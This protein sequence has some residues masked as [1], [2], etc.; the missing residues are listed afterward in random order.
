M[1]TR[2]EVAPLL[3]AMRDTLSA[4]SKTVLSYVAAMT[5]LFSLLDLAQVESGH[6]TLS[7]IGSTIAGYLL[8]RA[9][10]VET[11]LAREGETAGFG[12]YF[13]MG[14]LEGL[15]YV[16]GAVLLVVPA[17]IL[18]VRWTPSIPLL[19]CERRDVTESM[20]LSW[21]STKDS[22]WPL[23]GLT[24]L[25]AVPFVFAVLVSGVFFEDEGPLTAGGIAASLITNL[26][27]TAMSAYFALL[28]LATYRLLFRPHE[29]L[30][31]VFA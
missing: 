26:C 20:G 5:V 31:E 27:I 24:L 11:G 22:F 1:E 18:M 14:F 30:A 25:G 7:S 23:L 12:S 17:V 4:T 3:A 6:F 29:G 15:A 10:V 21:Q 28:A 19:M 16:V 2:I 9:L 13:G 8:M